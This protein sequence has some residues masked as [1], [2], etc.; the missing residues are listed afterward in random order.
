MT[1]RLASGAQ[2]WRLNEAGRLQL[3]E[4]TDPITSAQAKPLVGAI[5][6]EKPAKTEKYVVGKGVQDPRLFRSAA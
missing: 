2:L 5:L 6:K 1:E 4:E 3:V